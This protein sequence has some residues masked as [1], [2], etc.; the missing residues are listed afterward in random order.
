MLDIEYVSAYPF[1][2]ENVSD[3]FAPALILH[4]W[5]VLMPLIVF[6]A[7]LRRLNRLKPCVL[8]T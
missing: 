5:I 6:D 4:F 7:F 3:V 1:N 8:L 2:A